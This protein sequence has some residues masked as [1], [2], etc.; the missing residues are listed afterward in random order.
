[1]NINRVGFASMN[2]DYKPEEKAA[3]TF[4]FERI[5]QACEKY[6]AY[7]VRKAARNQIGGDN[8]ALSSVELDG[9]YSHEQLLCISSE[10]FYRMTKQEIHHEFC[11]DCNLEEFL[12]FSSLHEYK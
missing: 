10:A 5:V 8:S 11:K 12:D 3:P 1:M 6:G 4:S 2:T 9:H 7:E